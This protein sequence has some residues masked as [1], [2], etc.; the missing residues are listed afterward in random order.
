MKIQPI[1]L[2][3]IAAASMSLAFAAE[4]SL[5]I[6]Q[7]SGDVGETAIPGSAQYNPDNRE[8]RLTGSGENI[9]FQS[10]AFHFAWKKCSGDLELT[11]SVTFLGA[12]H[13]HRKAG[14]MIRQTLDHD[15]PYV[16]TVVHGNG[17]ASMQY[18]K[19]KDAPTDEVAAPVQ[20][21]ALI[22]LIREEN[23]IS[24]QVS[25]DGRTF[26]PVG[27][28][29][30]DLP[31][32]VYVGLAVC[33][34][35]NT[36]SRTAVFKNV[37]L[38]EKGIVKEEDRML[39]SN[40]E[41]MNIQT[42]RRKVIY[43]DNSRFEAPN[44]S[45]DGKT[46]LFNSG[47]RL[48][49]IPAEGGTPK[50]LDTGFADRCNND[51]GYSPD[52]KHIAVSHHD[53]DI[54]KIYI[55]PAEGG[56]PRLVTEKGPSYWHG[57][58]HDGKTLAYCAQRNGQFD[59]Y[60]IPADGGP[61]TR[62]TDAEGLDDGPEYSPDGKTIYFNSD[63]LGPMLIWKMNPDGAGQAPV[64][65]DEM[66]NDWFPHPSPDGKWIVFLSYDASVQGHPA[67]KEVALRIMSATDSQ[68]RTLT[69]L[70]GGQGTLNVN[71]WAPDAKQFAFVSYRLIPK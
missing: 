1:A 56:A 7:A 49:T 65:Y 41:I 27:S 39:Q 38:T 5:G 59:I 44:W 43:S 57:W 67:D 35:D 34:H 58:S 17:L 55:L 21:P 71:S 61:E 13:E 53:Q 25:E 66:Y 3:L 51:H 14:W 18:R 63:R 23:I 52:G 20:S 30:I 48:Y 15:A 12:G 69:R 40:L 31:D 24:M 10:D 32:P 68:P 26:H 8:Y 9:W 62:L 36:V 28:V 37:T 11:A 6:F 47:G 46:L 33:S 54:S 60:T 19:R 64:T 4:E 42:G 50:Q 29:V 2:I 22:K 16:D 70:F 45:R